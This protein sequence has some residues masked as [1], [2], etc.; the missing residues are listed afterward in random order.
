LQPKIAKNSLMIRQH[1]QA[2]KKLIYAIGC[3]LQPCRSVG[4][5]Q[6]FASSQCVASCCIVRN[7]LN[8]V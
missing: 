4:T 1:D 6:I 7:V 5:Q 8:C 2:S 3:G